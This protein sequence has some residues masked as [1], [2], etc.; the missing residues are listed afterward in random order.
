MNRNAPSP[1][2]CFALPQEAKPF[3]NSSPSHVQLLVTGMGRQ[4][5]ERTLTAQL[6]RATPSFVLTCG[7]AGVLDPA[8]Q[9]NTLLF[10]S[11]NGPLA[12][13]LAAAGARRARFHCATRMA[14]TAAQKAAL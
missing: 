3:Q 12:E 6:A 8:L 5:T 10:E 1:L 13:R 2:I 9:L 11:Q 4:N 14:V 7:F